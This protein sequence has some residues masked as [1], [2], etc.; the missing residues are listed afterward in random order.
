MQFYVHSSEMKGMCNSEYAGRL[1]NNNLPAIVVDVIVALVVLVSLSSEPVLP[2][3]LLV[4]VQSNPS[5]G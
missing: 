4:V 3:L 2:Q 5:N 1:R